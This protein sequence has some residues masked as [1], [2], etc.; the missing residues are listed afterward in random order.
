M[1]SKIFFYHRLEK[2]TWSLVVELRPS[3]LRR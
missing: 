3:D 2:G 1:E